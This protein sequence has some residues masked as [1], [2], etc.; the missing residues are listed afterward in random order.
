MEQEQHVF[1][2]RSWNEPPDFC[3]FLGGFFRWKNT[4]VQ[5]KKSWW[6][7]DLKA[8]PAISYSLLGNYNE[9]LLPWKIN[10][11]NLQPSPM[12][13]KEN[14]RKKPPG[15]YVPCQSSYR[16]WFQIFFTF[17]PTWGRFPFWPI[18]FRGLKP[19]TSHVGVCRIAR[20]ICTV[21]FTGFF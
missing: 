9:P 4:S 14:D 13:R 17:T 15:N 5:I 16:W 12:K 21:L 3:W 20:L 11:W 8:K 10:G 6:Q 7:W 2:M 18:F 19:P 1:S